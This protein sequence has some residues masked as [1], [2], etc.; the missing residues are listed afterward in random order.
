MVCYL[1]NC[2]NIQPLIILFLETIEENS[3]SRSLFDS[4]IS[5]LTAVVEKLQTENKQLRAK[6]QVCI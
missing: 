6:E 3:T 4:E 2:L 1:K 5:R